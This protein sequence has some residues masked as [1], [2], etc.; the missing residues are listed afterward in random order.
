MGLLLSVLFVG[1][2]WF[3]LDKPELF[4]LVEQGDHIGVGSY[5]LKHSNAEVKAALQYKDVWGRT[6]V[7]VAYEKS[8]YV[9]LSLLLLHPA[10]QADT[11]DTKPLPKGKV[12]VAATTPRPNF[13][14]AFFDWVYACVYPEYELIRGLRLCSEASIQSFL[15]QHSTEQIRIAVMYNDSQA[16][17]L[18]CQPDR[19]PCLRVMLRHSVVNAMAAATFHNVRGSLLHQAC[20][21]GWVDVVA[22]LL[23]EGLVTSRMGLTF[24][25]PL[26][27]AWKQYHLATSAASKQKYLGCIALI[28]KKCMIWE[29]WLYETTDNLASNIL[30]GKSSL[31]SW[32]RC[33][34]MVLG[35]AL[36]SHV[37]LVL[38]DF[39]GDKKNDASTWKRSALP[40]S[41]YLARRAD[42]AFESKQKL[43]NSKKFSFST[44]C[45]R[46]AL[47]DP[48]T[49]LHGAESLLLE[50][51]CMDATAFEAWKQFV[52]VKKPKTQTTTPN[53]PHAPSPP[54][55]EEV[56]T[57]VVCLDK[58]MEGVCVPCGHRAVCMTC[59][60]TLVAHPSNKCPICRADIRQVIRMYNC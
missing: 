30:G 49:L 41:I 56:G 35:T 19:I 36:T 16:L 47:D 37:E 44:T 18:A 24:R 29:G 31:Q 4:R 7:V 48:Q 45:V 5:L 38:Y 54:P 15:Q 17:W 59:A 40:T 39:V 6:A 34:C 52:A 27:L 57:C 50:F 3:E 12:A 14:D 22:C 26:D 20:L 21:Y 8:H 43:F 60:A 10:S 32:K 23:E 1:A 46:K 9:S 28:E 58:P 13:I 42:L 55:I 25:S 11:Q 33:Y 51:A 2:V 53:T